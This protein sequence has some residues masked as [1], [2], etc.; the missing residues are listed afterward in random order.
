MALKAVPQ[1]E[2]P[3]A[4][5]IRMAAERAIADGAVAFIAHWE[6]PTSFASACAPDIRALRDGMQRRAWL[7]HQGIDPEDTEE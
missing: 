6:T 5:R 2:S 3:I 4:T 7:M 1:T